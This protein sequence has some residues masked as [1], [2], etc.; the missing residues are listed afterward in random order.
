MS[1][2][3]RLFAWLVD[4]PS[5]VT[6]RADVWVV[7]GGAG[8]WSLT[9][10]PEFALVAVPYLLAGIAMWLWPGHESAIFPAAAQAS[11]GIGVVLFA[12]WVRTS[13]RP[14]TG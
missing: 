12:R 11:I 1:F 13:E 3:H 7:G 14:G 5:D 8:L 6:L 4:Q 10:G 9:I 2:L